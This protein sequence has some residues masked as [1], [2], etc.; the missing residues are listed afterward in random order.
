M[1]ELLSETFFII[2]G[3]FAILLFVGFAYAQ[4]DLTIIDVSFKEQG[5]AD[6]ITLMDEKGKIKITIRETKNDEIE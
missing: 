2:L 3:I 6:A 5:N 4:E 1:K